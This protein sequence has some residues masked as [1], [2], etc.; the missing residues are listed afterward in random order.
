MTERQPL[1]LTEREAARLLGL[2]PRFLQ[3]HRYRGDGP[4]FVRASAR[5]IRYRLEDLEQWAEQ[6]LRNRTSTG[7]ETAGADEE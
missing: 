1:L 5:T 6:R 3:Q 4:K 2:S 7:S